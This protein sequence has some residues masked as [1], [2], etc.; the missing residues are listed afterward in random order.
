M[1]TSIV[2]E[3]PG[4]E[5]GDTGWEKGSHVVISSSVV[6]ESR[7]HPRSGTQFASS[8]SSTQDYETY[9]RNNNVAPIAPGTSV[10][11]SCYGSGLGRDG[12]AIA[13]QLEWLNSSQV[14]ISQSRGPETPWSSPGGYYKSTVTG[15][16]P[17][18]AAFVRIAAFMRIRQNGTVYVDDFEWN[19]INNR[20]VSLQSPINSAEYLE[21]TNVQLR[22][23]IA[24]TQPAV[25]KVEYLDGSTV[26]ATTVTEDW[27]SG[28]SSLSVGSH[29]ISAK[30][31]FVDGSFLTTNAATI[32]V[33]ASPTAPDPPD[34]PDPEDPPPPQPPPPPEPPVPPPVP[35]LP[36]REFKASNSYTYL[37]TEGF[38]GLSSGMPPTSRVTGV[39]LEVDYALTLLVRAK[40]KNV[41]VS[42]ANANVIFDITDGGTAEIVLL[43][44][45]GDSYTMKGTSIQ[46]TIPIELA[47]FVQLEESTSEG[48]KWV[49]YAASEKT[50]IVGES[51]TLFGLGPMTADDF[52]NH[53]IGFK[54]YPILTTK[55]EYADSG[56][57]CI[58]FIIN[59]YRLRVYFD[60]GSAEYYFVSPDKT[61]VIKGT[62]VNSYVFLGDFRTLDA[63]GVLELQP[64]LEIMEGTQT[65]IGD[66]WTIHSGYPSTSD[67]HIGN[68]KIRSVDDGVGQSY[69]GL[70]TQQ[71][72]V[73]NRSR[74][75]FITANFYGDAKLD[76]IYGVNGVG[77]A[78]AYNGRFFHN[79][80][81]QP[82]A[83][84]DTPRHLAFHHHHLALGY[85]NGRIDISVVGEPFNFSGM[86]GASSWTTGDAVTGLLPL[87]GTLLGVFCKKSVWG[88]SGTTVDNFATQ[89]IA[90]RIGA[91]EYTVVDM[92]FPVYTNAY[93]IYTLQQTSEYGDYLGNPMSADVSPW[94]RPRLS[95]DETKSNETVVAWPVRSK[96][97]YNL[98]F[99][100]GYT[101]TMTLNYGSNMQPTFSI[102]KYDI[103][104]PEDEEEGPG[105]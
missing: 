13:V 12:N 35:E 2:I 3:N 87:T 71:A 64:E 92:G 4:F 54:F 63:D 36:K 68:V 85:D 8:H 61:Q 34:D 37:C 88:I 15:V 38:Q 44:N 72:I 45:N 67:N 7:A 17:P 90:P 77:R 98:V 5:S 28:I 26:I 79:I 10:T 102:R 78:F 56:D 30:V 18:S 104:V 93:G 39:Q 100:D 46:E 6:G 91:I 94:L 75:E 43:G 42:G 50:A 51:D 20:S 86:L 52:K 41:P 103:S 9:I 101:L 59:R 62:L 82:S 31:T 99:K 84:K 95:R 19:I 1:A 65:W 23:A 47:D 97:Q 81:T 49:V 89:V 40:D 73:D 58:R 105:Q 48:K 53:A 24:G 29:V 11:A 16:A 57:A 27:S 80:Y 74:Y 70:V 25:S 55:P 66:D 33:V 22:V 14:K 32:V 60:A 76:S 96:N 69:N 21:N 83:E